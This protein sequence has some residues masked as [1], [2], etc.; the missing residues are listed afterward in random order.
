LPTGDMI[1]YMR[2]RYGGVLYHTALFPSAVIG[3]YGNPNSISQ[4]ISV[5]FELSNALLTVTLSGRRLRWRGLSWKVSFGTVTITREFRPQVIAGSESGAQ[6]SVVFDVSKILRG[7]GAYQFKISCESAEPVKVESVSLLGITPLEGVEAEVGYWAGPLGLERGEEYVI[8]VG[9]A[10]EGEAQ[11]ILLAT[12]P[13][14]S[15]AIEVGT[16]S[17]V[18]RLTGFIGTD[19]RHFRTVLDA[20]STRLRVRY[21]GDESGYAPKMIYVNELIVYRPLNPGPVLKIR[22]VTREGSRVKFKVVNEGSSA[23]RNALIVGIAAGLPFYREVIPVLRPGEEMGLSLELNEGLQKP[24]I[25][26]LVYYSVWGQSMETLR[27]D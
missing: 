25:I 14:R 24:V 4:M 17:R 27:V 12:T 13:S 26:R 15:T 16:G 19:V 11:V 8:D 6:A 3:G 2:G 21:A 20:S 18:V 10:G 1:R 23:A 9:D 5:D 22:D 7:R